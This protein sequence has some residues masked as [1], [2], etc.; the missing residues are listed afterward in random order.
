MTRTLTLST[1]LISTLITLALTTPLAAAQTMNLID[2]GRTV[3]SLV[4]FQTQD[5]QFGFHT[6]DSQPSRS[7]SNWT[8][9]ANSDIIRASADAHMNSLISSTTLLG[10]GSASA[11]ADYDVDSS[12]FTIAF[13]TSRHTIDFSID[14]T[15][16]FSLIARLDA[17]GNAQSFARVLRD[18]AN[19]IVLHEYFAN[20]ETRQ[21]NEQITL[22][23]GSYSIQFRAESS[24]ELHTPASQSG[25]ATYDAAW[26]I[27]PA[28]STGLIAL[29]GLIPLTRRRREHSLK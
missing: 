23:P 22:D 3:E 19:G 2:D 8:G 15:T 26:S 16:T 13:A 7:F 18:H 24:I 29:A 20:N 10:S 25:L 21:L 9:D 27:V 28:P 17:T 14:T 4:E 1:T 6:R 5:D 11:F 12:V